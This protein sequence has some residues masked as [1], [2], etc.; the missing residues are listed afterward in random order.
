MARVNAAFAQPDQPAAPAGGRAVVDADF[1]PV[2]VPAPQDNAPPAPLRVVRCATAEVI[3]PPADGPARG[4]TAV[5]ELVRDG[6]IV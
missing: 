4:P 2:L 1:E 6:I 5:L 3:R